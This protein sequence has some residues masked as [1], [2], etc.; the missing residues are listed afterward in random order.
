MTQIQ[1]LHIEK[2]V[3]PLF[4][5]TRNRYANSFL[6][7]MLQTPMTSLKEIMDRQAIVQSFCS[8]YSLFDNY[9]YA[10]ADLMEVYQFSEHIR[11][12]DQ[13]QKGLRW[14]FFFS[15][16]EKQRQRSKHIQFVLLFY[17]L[18]SQFEQIN[19]TVFPDSY[20]EQ[21][22]A[23]KQFFAV[24]HLEEYE[25]SI[26]QQN[27]HLSHL[28]NLAELIIEQV[29]NK[30]FTAFWER[31][32]LFEAYV[33]IS[34]GIVKNK[35]VFPS[36]TD[37]G[38]SL[39]QF[40]FPVLK[41][42]IKNDL[43][44]EKNVI[45]FTGPNMSGK[46]TMLKAISLCVYLAHIGFAVPADRAELCYFDSIHVFINL[47]DDIKNGYSHFMTEIRNLKQVATEASANQKC[48]AVFD[49][50]F[51]GTN[52]EDAL[53]ISAITING[54]SK[55]E[56]SI[57]FISTHLHQL[58]E[59]E[60]IKHDKVAYYYVDCELKNQL[61]RFNYLLKEGWSDIKIGRILFDKEGLNYLLS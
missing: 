17:K 16:S 31:F 22:K 48:F 24:F 43:T 7:H 23:I 37:K 52:T 11:Q 55:F 38:I 6:L 47:S 40:Y 49:E 3:L 19:I 54:L 59:L 60:S 36:F 61:P 44:T 32:F 4:D 21:I 50:L 15:E 34:L 56:H 51:R 13:A 33:S 5:Y 10:S 12:N 45:L 46:S 30:Q 8:N 57:F 26:R 41:H 14:K 18:S 58:K 39:Q 9:A 1:D 35:F 29:A 27:F 28:F 25:Q 2:E 20:Q 42:P 53:E